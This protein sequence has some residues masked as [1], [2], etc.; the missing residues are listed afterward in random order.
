VF[1]SVVLQ[2]KD[3]RVSWGDRF[4][5][6]SD[7]LIE[8]APGG[9]RR[10]GLERLV[11][12]CVRLRDV[13]LAEAPRAIVNHVRPDAGPAADDLLLLGVEVRP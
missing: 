13:P 9:G 3:L 1:S 4:F 7:G 10:A 11:E 2:R 8:S 6:Y 5:L 12:A